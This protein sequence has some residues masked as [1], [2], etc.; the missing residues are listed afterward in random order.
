MKLIGIYNHTGYRPRGG[1]PY[2]DSVDLTTEH[3]ELK[4][5]EI[6]V[7]GPRVFFGS[8]RGWTVA[9]KSGDGTTTGEITWFDVPLSAVTLTWRGEAAELERCAKYTP[10]PPAGKVK[11]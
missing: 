5:W 4:G 2:F 7:R 6:H 8:P 10:G 9:T 1:L 11:P 3:H